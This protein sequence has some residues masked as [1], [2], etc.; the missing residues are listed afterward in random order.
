MDAGETAFNPLRIRGSA[1]SAEDVGTPI[2]GCQMRKLRQVPPPPSSEG[3]WTQRLDL[4]P[5]PLPSTPQLPLGGSHLGNR[6]GTK[7]AKGRSAGRDPGEPALGPRPFPP[8]A[9]PFPRLGI[10]SSASP[11]QLWPG[12]D[13]PRPPQS[14]LQPAAPRR[15]H[16]RTPSGAKSERGGPARPPETI[17]RPGASCAPRPRSPR[18]AAAPRASRPH[19]PSPPARDPGPGGAAPPLS[20]Q[21]PGAAAALN[22]GAQLAG[23]R[24][25]QSVRTQ[26]SLRNRWPG[27]RPSPPR[28]PAAHP[29]PR[30]LAAPLPTR[31][32]GAPRAAP[33][34]PRPPPPE[35]GPRYLRLSRRRRRTSWPRGPAGS[36]AAGG[37]APSPAAG[38]PPLRPGRGQRRPARRPRWVPAARPARPRCSRLQG[39][40][41]R[42][43]VRSAP[44]DSLSPTVWAANTISPFNR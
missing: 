16:S 35:R 11:P 18:G 17:Q 24:R 9:G 34:S 38:A 28:P 36:A 23:D 44:R 4:P 2:P 10:S 43:Q 27:P 25:A 5:E 42:Q 13:A 26:M 1:E 37:S 21:A 39:W 14:P 30:L 40:T 3:Q 31:A 29:R 41:Q 7:R 12:S 33:R 20:G 32:P 15:S 6:E 22:F 19:G 8:P